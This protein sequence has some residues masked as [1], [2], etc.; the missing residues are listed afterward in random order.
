MLREDREL[1]EWGL[2]CGLDFLLSFYPARF[3]VILRNCLLKR[4]LFFVCEEEPTR[5]IHAPSHN[6]ALFGLEK[7]TAGSGILPGIGMFRLFEL[8]RTEAQPRST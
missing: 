3:N 2:F 4:L 1:S 5:R 8:P 6:S 7:L